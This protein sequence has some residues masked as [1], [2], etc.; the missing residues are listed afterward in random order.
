MRENASMDAMLVLQDAIMEG[1]IDHQAL[2]EVVEATKPRMTREAYWDRFC[3]AEPWAPE[4]LIYD[5]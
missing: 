5:I 3:S 4:C 2:S 1:V